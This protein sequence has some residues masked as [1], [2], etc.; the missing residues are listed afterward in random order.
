MLIYGCFIQTFSLFLTMCCE[1]AL[2]KQK[3]DCMSTTPKSWL[4]RYGSTLAI[5]VPF[6]LCTLLN[7]LVRPWLAQKLDGI[8]VTYGNGV[9]GP[10]RYWQFDAATQAEHPALT[11]FLSCSD[12]LMSLVT[13]FIIAILLVLNKCAKKI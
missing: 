6:V 5:C 7:A 1:W 4:S 2:S 11:W 13:F 10:D 3:T 12:G 8:L 9:R